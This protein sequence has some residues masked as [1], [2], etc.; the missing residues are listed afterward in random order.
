MGKGTRASEVSAWEERDADRAER[1]DGRRTSDRLGKP[2]MSIVRRGLTGWQRGGGPEKSLEANCVRWGEAMMA[3]GDLPRRRVSPR[4]KPGRRGLLSAETPH[5]LGLLY[6]GGGQ[7]TVRGP[8]IYFK[9]GGV[10]NL[11]KWLAAS[12]RFT[13]CA[14]GVVA[15][16]PGQTANGPRSPPV[17][18][19]HL[20]RLRNRQELIVICLHLS[21]STLRPG[22]SAGGIASPTSPGEKSIVQIGGVSRFGQDAAL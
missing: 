5:R 8:F 3:Y 10:I 20:C 7:G 4:L 14:E 16:C 12:L 6:L 18:E 22:E 21:A 11:A 2:R 1:A 17:A 13:G 19:G 15:R 9:S